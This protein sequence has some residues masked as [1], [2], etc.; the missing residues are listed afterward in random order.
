MS[1][2]TEASAKKPRCYRLQ[3]VG[4][5]LGACW[6]LLLLHIALLS[7]GVVW[8]VL[9]CYDLY[10]QPQIAALEWTDERRASE[11]TYYTRYCDEND[12]LAVEEEDDHAT[13]NDNNKQTTAYRRLVGHTPEEAANVFLREG[14]TVL[15]NVLT[16]ELAAALR[17]FVL[18]K[19]YES[20]P[21]GKEFN[22][23]Y[24]PNNRWLVTLGTSDGPIVTQTLQHFAASNASA[25]ARTALERIIGPNPAL[26]EMDV[27]TSASGAVAQSVH[28]DGVGDLSPLLAARSFSPTHVLLVQL[29]DTTIAMG[30]T[31]VCPR[32]HYCWDGP[33]IELC[34]SDRYLFPAVWHHSSDHDNEPYWPAG[35]GILMNTNALH[36][37][38]A[39]TA[40]ADSPHRVMLVLTWAPHREP[41]AE[42]RMLTQ[43]LSYSLPPY[44]WG[45]TLR[46]AAQA[47]TVMQPPWTYLRAA[48]VWHANAARNHHLYAGRTKMP[49][50]GTDFVTLWLRR[51][52]NTFEG[53]DGPEVLQDFLFDNTGSGQSFFLWLHGQ[54]ALEKME[55]F[56]DFCLQTVERLATLTRS[57]VAIAVVLYATF[58]LASLR[59]RHTHSHAAHHAQ[60][61][62]QSWY[63]IGLLP[64]SF[65]GWYLAIRVVNDH[66]DHTTWAADIRAGT[67][68][69][70]SFQPHPYD[71]LIE[72]NCPTTIPWRTDILIET[73]F[74]SDY[75]AMYNKFVSNHPGNRQ[76]NHVV[77][78]YAPSFATLIMQSPHTNCHD[79]S[80]A[81]IMCREMGKSIVQLLH[82]SSFLWQSRRTGAWHVLSDKQATQQTILALAK[83]SFPVLDEVMTQ[84]RFLESDCLYGFRRDT[85][86]CRHDL[87]F[88]WRFQLYIL[89]RYQLPE[90]AAENARDS[91]K[92]HGTP[93][94]IATLTSGKPLT[95]REP[96]TAIAFSRHLLP[97]VE[98]SQRAVPYLPFLPLTQGDRVLVVWDDEL[99]LGRVEWVPPDGQV[100]VRLDSDGSLEEISYQKLFVLT[101]TL[102]PGKAIEI[103]IDDEEWLENAHVV[104]L[105]LES[106]VLI[107]ATEDSKESLTLSFAE[108]WRVDFE[109]A[110][111]S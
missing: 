27:I 17:E 79:S 108:I 73:R 76:W 81:A 46:D 102:Y 98:P 86:L 33:Y 20:D 104:D 56:L 11:Y 82:D 47:D 85:A 2:A 109:E 39:Y 29:Q 26:I 24:A 43:G 77:T 91:G 80:L 6:L 35:T 96:F 84:L 87:E 95:Q 93:W 72:K 106:E 40:S 19:N 31:Q 52:A 69:T 70:V 110:F 49:Q 13:D 18:Q 57:W 15:P 16:P 23:L 32:T 105:D 54:D 111:L 53:F 71:A 97:H 44:M 50:W 37:G 62:S 25:F 63:M 83:A 66:I 3:Q 45:H 48:G 68:N 41:R 5:T 9:R 28:S 94:R 51:F 58:V 103:E 12:L 55:T 99:S 14:Y 7:Y 107:Y 34:Q 61:Q 42:A 65:L 36:R 101:R 21:T 30:A 8:T 10:L 92:A 4:F 64:V 59:T 60:R 89:D 67:L 78:E 88:L 74:G 100:H 75:L 90:S 38:A 1:G 22:V